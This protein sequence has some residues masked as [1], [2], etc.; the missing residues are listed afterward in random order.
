MTVAI[1]MTIRPSPT[2]G[3]DE[4]VVDGEV[5]ARSSTPALSGARAMMA[6]GMAPD[7]PVRVRRESESGE[8][9]H[10]TL[11]ALDSLGSTGKPRS[12]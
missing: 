11:A 1:E 9:Y 7:T 8:G 5:V 2:G 3:I 6:R 4:V 12:G 10:A